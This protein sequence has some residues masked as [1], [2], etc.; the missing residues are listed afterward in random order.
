MANGDKTWSEAH[1][2]AL[3]S[4][5]PPCIQCSKMISQE[6]GILSTSSMPSHGHASEFKGCVVGLLPLAGKQ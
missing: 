6:L 1:H 4:L 2:L 3:L 5:V